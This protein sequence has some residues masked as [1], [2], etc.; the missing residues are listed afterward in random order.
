MSAPTD[1]RQRFRAAPAI[2]R[3]GLWMIGASACFATLTAI[4][5]HL[6]DTVEVFEIIFFRNLF[7]L[8]V[9]APWFWR[10]GFGGLRTRRLGLYCLRGLTGLINMSCWFYAVTFIALAD[11]TALS[12]TAPLFAILAAVVLLRERVRAGRWGA[13]VAGFAGALLILRPGGDFEPAALIMLV[14][15]AFMALSVIIVKSLSRT[16]PAGAIVAWMGLILTP[17]SLVPALFVWHWPSLEDLAW[18]AALGAV[19]TVGHYGFTRALA[20]AEASAVMPFDFIRL[21]F[22]ALLGFLAFGERVDLWTW[23]GGLIIFSSALY[24][25]HSEARADAKA[26][27]AEA[28]RISGPVTS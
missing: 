9:L 7:G 20:S 2:V 6:S 22:A 25:G 12:F 21:P 17:A 19:A 26:A 14:S 1:L 15:A 11:V 23:A 16:E 8:I 3:G 13:T 24:V 27:R 18:L 10:Y 4:I 28:A 5:R